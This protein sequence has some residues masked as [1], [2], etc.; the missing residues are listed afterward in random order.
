MTSEAVAPRTRLSGNTRGAFWLL[1]SSL[2]FTAMTL[3]V[4][5][6]GSYSP[7]M[8][9]VWTQSAGL[10]LFLPVILSSRGAVLVLHGWPAQIGRSISAVLGV[11]L[12][13]YALHHL[14]L[15]EANALS[16][17]RA[18]WVGPLAALVLREQVTRASWAAL[19]FGFVGVLLVLQP[20]PHMTIGWAHLAAL[21]SALLLALT[22][23]GIKVLLRRNS[24]T[25]IMLWSSILGILFVLP[26]AILT[27][28]WPSAHDGWL[29]LLLGMVS[30]AMSTT[31]MH[32]MSL[33]DAAKI[34]A[35]DYVRLPLAIGAGLLVFGTVPSGWM[36]AGSL[37]II[38]TTV[39]AAV[40]GRPARIDPR[41]E[42]LT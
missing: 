37:L 5:L 33:G 40:S 23:T 24:L 28:R 9:A 42:P 6:L 39:W 30:V 35:V 18:L 31:Y 1:I 34:I 41:E 3:L 15:G 38:V 22:V 2:L 32:A 16:F 10:L 13:Y 14:P 12:S 29:L 27:W 21:A 26:P 19:A 36:I 7:A 20:S 11:T 4:K 17:T 25:T 8:Q